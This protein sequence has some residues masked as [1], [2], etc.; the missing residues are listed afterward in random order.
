MVLALAGALW[1]WY[2][3][4]DD[5]PAAVPVRAAAPVWQRVAPGDAER[6]RRA[7]ASLGNSTGPA[8]AS[9]TA[10]EAASYLIVAAGK[11]LPSS[12]QDL[13]AAVIGDR[14]YLRSR[15]SL[16]DLGGPAVLGPLATFV[17]ATDTLQLG[18]TIRLVRAGLGEFQV[19]DVRVRSLSIPA[20]V[21]PKLIA[22]LRRGPAEGLSPDGLPLPLPPFVADVR[23]ANGKVTL[24]RNL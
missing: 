2:A 18:G 10:A 1:Y 11:Q 20:R 16:A 15:V 22:Q 23:I 13:S 6:A 21:I 9:L 4:V 5:R 7:T 17:G 14:L 24:Y 8:F 3:R 19:R 12:A